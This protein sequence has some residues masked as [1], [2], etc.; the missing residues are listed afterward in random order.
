MITFP[1]AKINLGLRI[2]SRRPDGYHNLETM[3]YPIPLC[4]ALEVVPASG[5]EGKF[6]LSGINLDGQNDDNLII[7]AY[8]L[9]QKDFDIPEL[10]I[11]LRKNIPI[12]AGLGGGSSDAAFM[13]KLLNEYASLGINTD[14]LEMYASCLGADCPF[15]IR[16]KPIFAEGTGNEFSPIKL[17]LRNYYLILIKPEI[18]ISTKEAF[19]GITPAKPEIPLKEIIKMPV[20]QWKDVLINDF[21]KNI[22]KNHPEIKQVKDNLYAHGAIY[23]SMSGSGSSVFGIFEEKPSWES[24]REDCRIFILPLDN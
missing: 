1:N 7:K 20:T 22:C 23:A 6:Q 10:D 5:K 11:Y 17:S 4:D 16:N 9:L 14:D 19:A 2:I 18:F 15:F 12:G 8:R 24:G 13:L 21:E 3:F